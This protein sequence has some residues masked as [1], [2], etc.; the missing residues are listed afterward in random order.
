MPTFL[1]SL[2]RG[3]M[4][5]F[6]LG[7]TLVSP[8]QAQET[9]KP[10]KVTIVE[11][12]AEVSERVLPADPTVRIQYLYN[13]NMVFGVMAEGKRLTPNPDSIQTLF[14]IDGAVQSPKD[15]TK[16]QNFPEGLGQRKRHGATSVWQQGDVRVTMT[17]EVIAGKPSQPKP[18]APIPR[19]LDT[20]LVK[21]TIENTG[22]MPHKVGCR[23]FIDT[24][25]ANNDGALF[26]SPTTHPKQVL[27]GVLLEGKKLPEFLEVL[28]RPNLVDPGFKGIFTF[29][30]GSKMEGPGKVILTTFGARGNYNVPVVPSMGDSACA[31]YW[32]PQELQPQGKREIA[33]AYGQGVACTNEGRVQA[34]FG[35]SF[36]PGKK[37]TI[38]TYV[39][40]P[41]DGQ[42][43]TLELP[44]GLELADGKAT[45]VVPPPEEAGNSVVVW[46]CRLLEAG[47]YPIRISSS[48]GVTKTWT[49]TVSPQ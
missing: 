4:V 36:E 19:R 48:T 9:A 45:Q 26:A 43:L 11:D 20:L 12:K 34:E 23:V 13:G 39:D 17:L 3:F 22:N 31:L 18:G 1:P 42:S 8:A 25:V 46:R 33:Y 2:R 24:M 49:V 37:F 10:Y 44:K 14:M 47:V 28:E 35:G 27:N 5:L 30:L 21:Y 15:T 7:M 32:E 40:D 38:T 41:I 16:L 29:K 6:G